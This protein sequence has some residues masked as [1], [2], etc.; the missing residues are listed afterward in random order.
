MN[1]YDALVQQSAPIDV[2]PTDT[3]YFSKLAGG[4]D[5]RLFINGK[6]IPGVRNAIL[7]ILFEHL[8]T[9]FYSPEDYA[10]VW[11]AGSGVS[12]QWAAQRDPADLDC[13]I[14]IDYIKFR[15][16]NQKYITLSDREIAQTLNEGFREALHPKTEAFLGVFELTFYVNVVSDITKIKPYA[17]YS[18]TSDSWTV[19]PAEEGASIRK[20]WE[21]KLEKDKTMA[22][23][24]LQRYN[25]AYYGV[26]AAK[27][28]AARRN[29][30][31]A[32]KLAVDQGAALFDSIHK[33]RS[34]A[35]TPEGQGYEDYANYRWQS[36]KA[37]GVIPA[38]KRMKEISTQTRKEFEAHTYGMELPDASLLVRR[39]LTQNG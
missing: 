8:K 31:S 11:L 13:L 16:A 34:A 27:N 30:E 20:D 24:I 25:N 29:A 26:E 32:L 14:G 22:L 39:A 10:H 33:G 17:A 36:G 18:V 5:P 19:E 37:S 15:Q 12:Y 23:E 7:S 6:L 1:Y 9:R 35:F 3:S 38:L 28:D 2:E 4:L 21:V